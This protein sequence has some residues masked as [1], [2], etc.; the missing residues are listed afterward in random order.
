[1]SW[2]RQV[3]T[4]AGQIANM[5][6]GV[7][8]GNRKMFELNKAAALAQAAVGLPAA[9]ID[10]YKNAG[11]YPLGIAAAAAMA[12]A[13]AAQIAQIKN[14]KFGGGLAPSQAGTPATPVASARAAQTINISG[15]SSDAI[16]SGSSVRGLL[17]RLQEAINDGGTLVLD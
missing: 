6:A 11:G 10:S 4:V 14:A 9:I 5:T 8:S 15:L 16:F 3:T 12:A 7:A 2:D 1:M 13:G 17:E